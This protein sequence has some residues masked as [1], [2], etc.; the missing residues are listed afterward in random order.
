[1]EEGCLCQSA[2]LQSERKNNGKM[3]AWVTLFLQI[4]Q[5][6]KEGSHFF[7]KVLRLNN[8]NK[9]KREKQKERQRES[10]RVTERRKYSVEVCVVLLKTFVL[11][12][13]PKWIPQGRGEEQRCRQGEK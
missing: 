13:H 10:D 12:L 6:T 1:M 4:R 3:Q 5:K 7:F 8:K 2:T 11:S 9:T